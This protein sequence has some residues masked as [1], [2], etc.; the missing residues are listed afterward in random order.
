MA[1]ISLLNE[2]P[3]GK[4]LFIYERQIATSTMARKLF[5]TA[6]DEW[7]PRRGARAGRVKGV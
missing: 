6:S 7:V 3:P 4:F 5:R 1:I 2:I